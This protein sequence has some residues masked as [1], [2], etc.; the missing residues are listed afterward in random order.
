MFHGALHAYVN[1]T[2]PSTEAAFNTWYDHVHLPEL[3]R[4]F[5]E[6]DRAAR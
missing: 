5:P 1:P 2:S 6:V 3:R 4:A